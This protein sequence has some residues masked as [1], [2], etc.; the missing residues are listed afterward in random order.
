MST[1]SIKGKG[2]KQIALRV[3][4]DL[5]AGI[6]QALEK[7]GDASVSAWIKRIIRKE[8]QQRGIESK[9]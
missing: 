8:L 1:I 5:E 4:P 6:K 3:E 7:D 9:S 2:N